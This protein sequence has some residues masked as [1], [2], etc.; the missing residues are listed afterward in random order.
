[1]GHA[2]KSNEFSE[3][4]LTAFHPP[5]FSEN[6]NAIFSENVRK[7]P[8]IKDQNLQYEFWMTPPP[9]QTFP[10]TQLIW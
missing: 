10:K 8:F 7:K 1:M 2:I 5:S 9:F 6:Y 4:F 3:K